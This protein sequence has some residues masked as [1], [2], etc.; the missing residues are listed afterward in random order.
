MTTMV[1]LP[2]TSDGLAPVFTYTVDGVSSATGMT[3]GSSR[4]NLLKSGANDI[5][6]IYLGSTDASTQFIGEHTKFGSNHRKFQP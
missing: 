1:F 4:I 2:P 6:K 5:D 3:F